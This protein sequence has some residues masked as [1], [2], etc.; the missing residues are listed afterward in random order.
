MVLKQHI[1]QLP[2][3]S[4]LLLADSIS[5]SISSRY[6]VTDLV[7]EHDLSCPS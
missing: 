1:F 5:Y 2:H 7:D 6:V 4:L 3:F